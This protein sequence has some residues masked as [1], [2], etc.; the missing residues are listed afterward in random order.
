M[1]H[2]RPLLYPDGPVQRVQMTEE[3]VECAVVFMSGHV[4][5]Y[6]LPN[7][8]FESRRFNATKQPAEDR[9]IVCLINSG[10]PPFFQKE[11]E[12]ERGV[13]CE[14][15][16]KPLVMVDNT[17]GSVAVCELS[18]IGEMKGYYRHW[19]PA[20]QF[21]PLI[22]FLAIGYASGAIIIIDLRGPKIIYREDTEGKRHSRSMH[23][24]L[25]EG[26]AKNTVK[27][28]AWV[29]CGSNDSA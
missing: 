19:S 24:P 2:H 17:W 16:Y 5:V 1:N 26:S 23:R 14:G 11:G 28:L 27:A 21:C 8:G 12:A 7:E 3:S 9:E 18:N 29:C 13:G 4:V 15:G 20:H 6:S 22:G 10:S 25:Q